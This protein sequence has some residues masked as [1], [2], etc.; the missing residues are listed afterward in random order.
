MRAVV[1]RVHTCS[2]RVEQKFVG[3]IEKGL[4]VYLGVEKEDTDED[5]QY[6][7]EKVSGLRI[8]S[9]SDGKMNLSVQD[10]HGQILV[11]SQFTLCADTR[12]GKRPSYNNAASPQMGE[13][14]Y[15][16]FVDAV[17]GKGIKVE[18]G[19]FGGKMQV[20]YTNDGP[21]TILLDSRKLF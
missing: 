1:Q 7:I 21:V 20:E 6:L 4:L 9:D 8:F 17:R 10:I 2:V 14:Y 11:I 18:T 3:Q 16:R 15:N 19:V 13:Q 5:M 12:K